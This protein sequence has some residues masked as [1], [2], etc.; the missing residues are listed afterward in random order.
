VAEEVPMIPLFNTID[1]FVTRP[2]KFDGWMFRY[3]HNYMDA[4]K[5]SYVEREVEE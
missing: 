5:L 1:I 3:D 4:C 2:Q